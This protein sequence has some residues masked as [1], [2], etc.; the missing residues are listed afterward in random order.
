VSTT[1]DY[2]LSALYR[3]HFS[4]VRTYLVRRL[5]CPEAGREAAQD[6]FLRLLTRPRNGQ[7]DN[8]RGFLLR[9]ARNLAIDLARKE[10]GRPTVE[11]L[12]EHAAVLLDPVSDPG[13]IVSAR[14]QL[15]AVAV[16]IEALPPKC[17]HVFFLF[18]FEGL[19]QKEIAE[20]LTISAKMVEAHLAR[21]MLSLR[22]HWAE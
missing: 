3:A 6:V 16:G 17:R 14:Q 8:P 12:E 22:R 2:D 7:I 10:R 9:A 11:P 15:R 18:R 1:L 4:A 19:K 21:A 13:R 20:R 5:G